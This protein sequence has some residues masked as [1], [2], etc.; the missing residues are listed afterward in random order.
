MNEIG[1][2]FEPESPQIKGSTI[3]ISVENAPEE[4]LL[5]K[6][7][8][9]NDGTW[10]TVKDFSIEDRALW[11]PQEPGRYIVMVQA[12]R[13]D[14]TRPFDYISRAD[15]LIGIEETRLI[16][17]LSLDKYELKVGEK[18]NI[19]IETT[20][21]P[22]LYKYWIREGE[23]WEVLKEY[24]PENTLSFTV[25]TAGV[26]EIMVQCKSLDSKKEFEDS[27]Q[28]QFEVEAIE[29]LQI[30]DFE[31]LSTDL[32]VDQELIFQVDVVH[33]DRRSILYKFLKINPEGRVTCVQDYST[34][35][36]VSFSE[37]QIGRYKLLCMAKDMYSPK[38]Y[39]DRAVIAYEVKPYKPVV[40]QSFTTDLGSPQ[41]VETP[42]ELKAVVNGG[43]SLL[44]RFRV[45]GN[46]SIDSGYI[47]E[48]SYLWNT[49]RP[50]TY[51]IELWVK[52]CSF[53]GKYETKAEIE[54]VIDEM[55]KFP[56]KIQ[57]VLMNKEKDYL[58]GEPVNVKI[59]AEG[60]LELRYS[61]LL[62]KDGKDI[63]K[64]EYGSCSW[65]DFIPKEGGNYELEV[66]VKDKYSP[67]EYDS[68]E[69]MNF[70]VREFI[71]AQIDYVLMPSKE[72]Y[73]VGDTIGFE[74]IA[75]NTKNTSIKYV[76][77]IN[78]HNV[79][80][81]EYVRSKKYSFTP[82]CSGYYVVELLARNDRSKREFDTKKEV[83]V[84]IHDTT[85]IANSK[86]QCDRT[87]IVV[88]DPVIFT[89]SS[90]GGR[91]VVYEFYLMDKDEW[92][93]VQKYSKK[94]YYSFIPFIEGT[95][96]M[97]VLCKSSRNACS[98]EDYAV[99]EFEVKESEYV[100]EPIRINNTKQ[101][102]MDS[103]II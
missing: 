4:R 27:Q 55:S 77:K 17:S 82:K 20:R 39:D 54:Y 100:M 67:K 95:F 38:E 86:L 14:S 34:K 50:G 53:E 52:D 8:V 79:E 19:T 7:F 63:E 60:G 74:V 75:Q 99:M 96:K 2:K 89:A 58:V 49:Q 45:D 25:K 3:E 61:F 98:Y 80:E 72:Y 40:I 70:D 12:K 32:L 85:P 81:T 13:E 56:V 94:N 88:N 93:I 6:F 87:T 101:K 62:K 102:I 15:Y 9:G 42:V 43:K 92:S 16:R 65:I 33:E 76:L 46:A 37:K 36:M 57:E 68:H 64:V 23:N 24:C 35:R 71:P 90:D 26:H 31:C 97:L 21:Q 47:K 1:I 41:V 18:L 44:Y 69:I 84:F 78:G 30:T 28:V 11:S 22:A 29:Q 59:I 51:K 66:R 10:E 5:Y 48:S 91:D 83:K 73:M 103:G